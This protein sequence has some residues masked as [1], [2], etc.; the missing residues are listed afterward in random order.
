MNAFT[1][2]GEFILK[3]DKQV[4]SSMDQI[5]GRASKVGGIFGTF[6][7]VAAAGFAAAA[8][9]AV[10]VGGALLKVGDDFDKAYN[11][12]RIGTGATGEAF[13]DMQGIVKNMATTI[14]GNLGDMGY[15]VAE[16]NT[17]LGLSGDA[18]EGM[19]T[20]MVNLSRITDENVNSI[21]PATT[22]LF[23]DW[24]IAAENQ[25]ETLDYLMRVSQNTGIGITE[26]SEKAVT[27]GASLRQMGFSFEDATLLLGKF[28]KEGVNTETMLASLKI[29]LN[30][31][32]KEG[33]TDANEALGILMDQI[34]E[35]PSDLEA[36]SIATEVFGSRASADMAAA[37]R[38]GRFE[39]EDLAEAVKN[40]EDTINGLAEETMTLGE[41]FELFKNKVFV[42]V[43][44][45]A[46]NL[47][48][49]FKGIIDV[50]GEAVIPKIVE[51]VTAF[52][53]LIN[54]IVEFI[55][56]LADRLIPVFTEIADAVIPV[57][58][59]VFGMLID[60]ALPPLMD[61]F[62]ML[63][64]TVL[65]PLM[66]VFGQIVQAVLPPFMQIFK[67]IVDRILPPFMDLFTVIVEKVL[68]PFMDLFTRLIETVLPP[69]VEFFAMLVETIMPPF[70][71]IIELIMEV[72]SP[73]IDLFM[74]ILEAILPP[75]MDL[76]TQLVKAILPPLLDIIKLL[77][78]YALKPLLELFGEFIEW[79][80]PY[81][82]KGIEFLT[83]TAIPAV[84]G[85]FTD[86]QGT[87]A[88]F[89][90]FFEAFATALK[91][92]WEAVKNFFI[93]TWNNIKNTF[94]TVGQAIYDFIYG[95]FDTLKTNLETIW[96]G[97]KDFFMGIWDKIVEK[98]N[99][100]RDNFVRAWDSIRDGVKDSINSIIKFINNLIR[101][102]ESGI[103]AIVKGL[104]SI[105]ITFP[106]WEWMPEKYRGAGW[107]GLGLKTVSLGSIPELAT[108][109]LID[110]AGFVDVG[111]RGRERV[112]LP[113][114]AEVRPL[115][116][117]AK[118]INNYNI[119]SPKPLNESETRRQI[120]LLTRELA[121]RMGL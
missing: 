16:L 45:L 51:L 59:D 104:N 42:A 37:I 65:P 33:V 108:G 110:K 15:A 84:I 39:L 57:V 29:G 35:A 32:A 46:T 118:I 121:Y 114:G 97:I 23:G 111:E 94:L 38:E 36:V 69:L 28:E 71:E 113:Q 48:D 58:T 116:D 70:I 19:S 74:E 1:I 115:S 103:N 106:D 72:L 26:L 81:I 22:R 82:V 6:G 95:T 2:A 80:L 85:V 54:K 44:P 49:A 14:P 9:A 96:N 56:V 64:S 68:P 47:M 73:F 55:P 107:S 83:N 61:L 52:T 53:P 7:K 117:G 10:A 63:A 24:G 66:R 92:I 31:M 98:V 60:E 120:D 3:G 88:N 5:E 79:A 50:I 78:E 77:I 75:L 91:I 76:F 89:K 90:A 101:G 112:Y 17:R 27:S 119:T 86:W 40:S 11:T 43:E 4:M 109:G 41:R 21:I 18:L 93:E 87:V 99:I 105:K 13:E 102:I 8:T 67:V 100:F 62:T 12:I 20:K 30:N 34:K 25:S